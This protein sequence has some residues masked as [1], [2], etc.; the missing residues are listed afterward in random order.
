MPTARRTTEPTVNDSRQ[1]PVGNNIDE[2]GNY[3]TIV[4]HLPLDEPGDWLRHE[5][6]PGQTT[7]Q[8]PSPTASAES[9]KRRGSGQ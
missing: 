8:A 3:L 2:Q 5:L 1:R 6:D 7:A 9:A 4:I